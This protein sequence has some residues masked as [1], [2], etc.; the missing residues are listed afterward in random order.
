[1]R[2]HKFRG[3]RKDTDEWVYGDLIH[4]PWGTMIQTIETKMP[5]G[6]GAPE[7]EPTKSRHKYAV[8]PDTVGEWTGL[9]MGGT[10]VY[11]GDICAVINPYG[12]SDKQCVVQWDTDGGWIYEP[13]NGYGDYDTSTIGWARSLGYKFT[14]IGN[15]HTTP[16]LLE[17]KQHAD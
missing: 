12:D 2:E 5:T 7:A 9:T 1:M 15:I 6:M 14:V 8:D 16:E 4:E 10:D 3:R 13:E 17:A 11:E